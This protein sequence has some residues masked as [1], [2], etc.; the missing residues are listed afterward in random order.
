MRAD[1]VI[2]VIHMMDNFIGPLADLPYTIST[3]I[4]G[5]ISLNRIRH[6]LFRPQGLAL[7]DTTIKSAASDAVAAT[8]QHHSTEAEPLLKEQR[9]RGSGEE[10]SQKESVS[11]ANQKLLEVAQKMF[12]YELHSLHS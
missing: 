1:L 11:E 5:Q 10:Q 4:E 6:Y 7:R 12:Q 8:S 2:P 3:L 9:E